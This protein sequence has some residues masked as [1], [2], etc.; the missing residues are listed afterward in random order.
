MIIHFLCR[1]FDIVIIN[2]ENKQVDRDGILAAALNA[3]LEYVSTPR[4]I[5]NYLHG[6]PTSLGHPDF[7]FSSSPS[8]ASSSSAHP[9]ASPS[10]DAIDQIEDE[11]VA[12]YGRGR[13]AEGI[14]QDILH[15]ES[16]DDG[17]CNSI[18]SNGDDDSSYDREEEDT[19]E[20]TAEKNKAKIGK[21]DADDVKKNGLDFKVQQQRTTYSPGVEEAKA[22]ATYFFE[23]TADHSVSTV[24]AFVLS[25][26]SHT[27]C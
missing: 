24:F 12:A 13:R 25:A 5:R 6:T 2:S 20:D 9:P 8:Q 11:A 3:T 27:L 10:D 1:H 15:Y 22:G 4:G 23:S 18:R 7:S 16:E 14:R 26:T 19:R 17:T 21:G